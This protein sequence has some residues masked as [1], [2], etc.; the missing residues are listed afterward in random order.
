MQD[1]S[2]HDKEEKSMNLSI[3][4]QLSG[5][6]ES[7]QCVILTDIL[8]RL[9]TDD[10]AVE[11]LFRADYQQH[12]DGKTLNFADFKRHLSYLRQRVSKI[13]FN[14]LDVCLH[15]DTL[16]ERHLVTITH[17]DQTESQLEV[18]MFIR[19]RDKKIES[20]HEVTRLVAGNITDRELASAVA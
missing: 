10:I 15:E 11:A 5:K 16:G 19:F 17:L 8:N 13:Q 1:G 2:E 7:E 6:N 12:S 9:F 18:Y 14:V 4:H 20:T 3:Q